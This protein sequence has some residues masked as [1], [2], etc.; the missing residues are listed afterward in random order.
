MVIAEV[1]YAHIR[2][3]KPYFEID[4]YVQIAAKYDKH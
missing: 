1:K 2:T 3:L 4:K